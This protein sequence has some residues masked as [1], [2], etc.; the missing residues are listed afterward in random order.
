MAT[1]DTTAGPEVAAAFRALGADARN[2]PITRAAADSA[3]GSW[4]GALDSATGIW[5]LGG[6]QNRITAAIGGTAV[7]RAIHRR[8]EAGAVVGGTSA[9]AAV[10]SA[11]MI[12]GEER[13]PGGA[14]PPRD[15]SQAWLTIDRGNVVTTRGLGLL[16]SAVVDQHF[17]RRRRNNRL[18][19]VVL[20]TPERFGV[21]VDE[22][23][24]LVVE[25]SGRWSVHGESVVV[26]YD[27]RPAAVTT[28]GALGAVGVLVHVLV[29]GSTYDPRVNA[30]T[31][32]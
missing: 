5:F 4:A 8:Y 18:L 9:G 15:S 26:V 16:R 12:T 14:R 3:G 13:R 11:T 20:E 30:I 24:A 27:A 2:L 25:P 10:L 1:A 31:F 22:S 32:P 6:D 19:S 29:P 23:T 17:V 28:R 21:G 7:E